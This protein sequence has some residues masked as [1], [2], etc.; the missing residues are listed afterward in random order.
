MPAFAI[1]EGSIAASTDTTGTNNHL[2][3][4]I[5]GLA[6]GQVPVGS[7]IVALLVGTE[8]NVV[9]NGRPDATN[10]R[11]SRTASGS[12]TIRALVILGCRGVQF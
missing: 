7:A 10:A 4:G 12:A 1:V 11:F 2:P 5:T 8:T 3:H 9:V 6:A